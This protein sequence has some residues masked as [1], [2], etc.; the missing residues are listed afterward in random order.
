MFNKTF[1]TKFDAP[2][3][4]ICE[5]TPSRFNSCYYPVTITI[6]Q[7]SD[8]LWRQSWLYLNPVATIYP[9]N[10]FESMYLSVDPPPPQPQRLLPVN[11]CGNYY[12]SHAFGSLLFYPIQHSIWFFVNSVVIVPGKLG[13]NCSVRLDN[14]FALLLCRYMC[15]CMG[16]YI[17]LLRSWVGRQEDD[18]RP[19][20]TS[21]EAN[22]KRFQLIF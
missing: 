12:F 10:F 15:V 11:F 1:Q 17:I 21:S 22:P 8:N 3:S 13:T 5:Y 19:L 6:S 7:S 18:A 16:A 14:V 9:S 2:L 4:L 20:G